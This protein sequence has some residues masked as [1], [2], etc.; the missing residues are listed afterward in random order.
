M[1]PQRLL[2]HVRI[3]S[4]SLISSCFSAFSENQAHSQRLQSFPS[5]LYAC[6]YIL[7]S[8]SS[9]LSSYLLPCKA[10]LLVPARQGAYLTVTQKLI[11]PSYFPAAVYILEDLSRLLPAPSSLD[12]QSQFFGPHRGPR[13]H[14]SSH[15]LLSFLR[16]PP[17][18]SLSLVYFNGCSPSRQSFRED[19]VRNT[20]SLQSCSLLWGS[21]P[22][23]SDPH[24]QP[25]AHTHEYSNHWIINWTPLL[26][27]SHSTLL[28]PFFFFFSRKREV[29]PFIEVCT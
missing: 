28:F 8:L 5:S 27:S 21:M 13:F 11:T 17:V 3:N 6:K 24:P 22:Q 25:P 29:Q 7:F 15:P 19:L 4:T 9:L 20:Y 10:I 1:G 12:W 16:S 18:S 2:P 23:W 14:T 26:R